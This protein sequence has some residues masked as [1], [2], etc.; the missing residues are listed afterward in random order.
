M[1]MIDGGFEITERGDIN[2]SKIWRKT[3]SQLILS[4]MLWA[5]VINSNLLVYWHLLH[6]L[7]TPGLA[8][9]IRKE[10][11]PYAKVLEP[12]SIGKISSAPTLKLSHDCLAKKCPL[13]KSTYFE[14]LRLCDQ[15]WSV[16]EVATEVV[17]SGDKASKDPASFVLRKGEYITIPHELHMRDPKYFKDPKT[18]DPE[19][20][21]IHNED[22]T[23]AT[24]MGTIRPYGGGPS[25]CKGR[26]FAERECLALVASVLMF[27]DIEPVDAKV[28][29]VIPK[30]KKASGISLPAKDTRVRIKRRK[31][32][33]EV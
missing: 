21:L 26:I 17:I 19:R 31:F 33:W 8:E 6:I 18:F 13:F 7:A 22:G 10:I 28:G 29:W 12:V 30:E 24:D 32:D 2:V 1:N 14:A 15:P 16:R 20:F 11:A 4:Q 27:W 3:W 5:L 25:M 23:L 9:R